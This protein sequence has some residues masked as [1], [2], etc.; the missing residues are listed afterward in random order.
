MG[1][2]SKIFTRRAR[3]RLA[4]QKR[5]AAAVKTPRRVLFETMESR[6][7]LSASPLSLGMVYIEEDI[8]SDLHGDRFEITFSG[9][10]AGTQLTRLVINGDQGEPGFSR[11][12]VI[13]DT[14]PGNLG[15]DNAVGFA[16]EQLISSNPQARVEA[17]VQDGS[18]LLVLDFHGFQAGDRLVFSIDVDEIEDVDPTE[19][20]LEIINEGLD[21]ITSGVE[22]QSSQLTATFTAPHYLDAESTVVFWNRYDGALQASGLDLSEDDVDGKRDRTAGAFL[23]LQQTM[24][25]VSISG[26]VYADSNDNGLREAGERGL[27]GVTVRVIPVNTFE[28]QQIVTLTTNAQGYYEARNLAPGTYRIVEVTQPAGYLDG[29][30]TP[31]T[32]DG[33]GSGRAV[34]PGDSLEDIFLPGGSRGEEY[35]FGEIEPAT[36]AGR[37]HL[38]DRYGN[39]PDSGVATQPLSG[40]TIHLLNATG[41]LV[42]QTTTGADGTYDFVGL[43]PG[44][45]SVIEFTPAGLIDAHAKAGRVDTV[46]RGRV[47]DPNTIVDVRLMPGDDGVEYNFCEHVPAELSGFVYHDRNNNGQREQGEEAIAG[48]R[49]TL[50]NSAGQAVATATTNAAGYYEFTGLAAD[51]YSVQESQPAGW[52]DGQDTIGRVDGVTIGLPTT[53]DVFSDVVL[54]WGSV[55]TDYNFGELLPSTLQGVVFVD[56]NGNCRRD[57]GES[58]IRGV[59]VELLDQWGSVLAT[60][61]TND[62]GDY[63]F[64]DLGPGTYSVRE[65]QPTGYFQGGQTAGSHGGDDSVDDIISR[66]PIQSDQRLT[67]YNF[68]EIP[69][70]GI[71]GIVYVDP[72]QNQTRDPGETLLQGVTIHLLDAQGHIVATTQ[73]DAAGYYEFKDLRPGQY[74]VRELQPT[75]YFQGGQQAGSHGGDA[76]STDLISRIPMGAGQTLQHYNFSELPPSSLEGMVYVTTGGCLPNPQTGIPGVPVELLDHNGNVVGT[77]LTDAQGRYHFDVLPPGIYSVRETQPGGYFQGGQCVGSGGG[78]GSTPDLITEIDILPGV[79]LR[80]YNFYELPP[81]TISGYVFQDGPTLQ[82]SDGK[83]PAHLATL[84]DGLR[85]A[86]D[87]PLAGV[88]VELRDGLTGFPILGEHLLP[89]QYPA[90]AV[91]AVTDA[92]GF[93]EF[94]GLPP[95]TYAVY[96]RHPGPYHDGIDTAGT[97][98]GVAFNISHLQDEQLA[99]YLENLAASLAEHPRDDAIVRIA[100]QAGQASV[101]NNFSEVL[102]TRMILP[103]EP[104]RPTP[105]VLEP[106]VFLTPPPVPLP[107]SLLDLPRSRPDFQITGSGGELKMTWHLSVINGGSPRSATEAAPALEGIWRTASY[108]D[109]VQW[110]TTT[111]N[112]GRWTLPDGMPQLAGHPR[113]GIVFGLAGA[114]PI[115]GDF[116]GDG[117][118][119]FGLYHEGHWFIDIN[120]NG[121]WDEEDLY[122]Q[123]GTLEDLPVVGDWDGDGKDDIGIFGPEWR[124]DQRAVQA[125]PGLPDT[126]NQQVTRTLRDIATS[127]TPKNLPPEAAEATDGF[128]VLKH[129]ASGNPRLDVIDHVFRFGMSDDHPLAGDWNGDGIPTIGVFRGGTW[130]LDLDG[131]GRFT[132]RDAVVTF[133]EEGDHPVV[134]DFDGDG[135]DQIG[136]YRRGIW[137]LDSDGNRQHDASD[138][139]IEMGEEGCKPVVGDWDADGKDDPG[140]YRDAG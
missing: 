55:A 59:K 90:G 92:N 40:V 57:N 107:P 65:T 46:T 88:T 108:L 123:L 93:Y 24:D 71:S 34:N 9:G 62:S 124:G 137:I 113:D 7:L 128:R 63:R 129:T 12:D 50:L 20:D 6:R 100:L 68:C 132:E 115:S 139:V 106:V 32:V 118:S 13:F 48:T 66:I 85:T 111:M 3:R 44:V 95:G 45:Y 21:P 87:R 28:P 77:T 131:D 14:A 25:P 60:T 79:T 67:E 114:I 64:T 47:V 96:E 23:Q 4:A 33:V 16:V 125:E 116:N 78:N 10:A 2:F 35:N 73:T 69:P 104:P 98:G 74:A 97:T 102:V 42:A 30:D 19:T 58:P 38:T 29:L 56:L 54:L 43:R 61:T 18:S 110:V 135:I 109:H 91:I 126:Q 17:H 52:L 1:L 81:A 82:T 130:Y 105:T 103:P 76:S 120:G 119:E 26:Y 127:A 84:R 134:G 138:E 72:N 5:A 49:V 75:G 122:A 53:N 11:G 22:F 70:A 89:G 51:R 101:E 83:V 41:S 39:C 121:K 15:A 112:Q 8:G 117:V 140:L 27:A 94:K 86:D 37:V 99:I 133:G 80:R 31:G 136:V 36:I